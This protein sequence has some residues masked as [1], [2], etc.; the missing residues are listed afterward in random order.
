MVSKLRS[1]KF[2]LINPR[3]FV[4]V[5]GSTGV[6][7][8]Y[9]STIQIKLINLVIPHPLYNPRTM[10][11]DIG[12]YRFSPSRS[13]N[14]LTGIIVHYPKLTEPF[15]ITRFVYP[16]PIPNSI[17]DT[18]AQTKFPIC[19][20]VGWGRLKPGS[21]VG[22]GDVLRKVRV[23]LITAEKCRHQVY[24]GVRRD[25]QLCAGVDEG[26]IDSCQGDSGGPMLCDNVQVGVVSWGIGCGNKKSPGIYSRVD[27]YLD[28]INST[29]TRNTVT[30]SKYLPALHRNNQSMMHLIGSNLSYMPD[31][32][33]SC[34]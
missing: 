33:N 8:L 15:R 18:L 14:R 4:A 27:Y 9:G 25:S 20:V 29:V 23:P 11:H 12:L 6:K 21:D 31:T 13:F 22:Y 24:S 10:H 2:K 17:D 16:S 30:V 3:V 26:G 5:A 28:W 34:R 32:P 19:T 7:N 1:G